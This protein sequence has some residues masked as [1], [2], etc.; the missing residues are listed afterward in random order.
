MLSSHIAKK[1]EHLLH[2][3][4]HYLM[5]VYTNAT[6]SLGCIQKKFNCSIQLYYQYF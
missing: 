6:V 5:V 2:F 1:I 4:Y 3:Q